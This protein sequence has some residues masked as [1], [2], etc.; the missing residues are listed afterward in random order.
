MKQLF[1]KLLYFFIGLLLIMFLGLLITGC[2]KETTVRQPEK[3]SCYTM[4]VKTNAAISIRYT[5]D[6]KTFTDTN[7][8][9]NFYYSF[10]AP[11]KKSPDHKYQIGFTKATIDPIELKITMDSITVQ[12]YFTNGHQYTISY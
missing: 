11:L 3:I 12:R 9:G 2:K 10:L 8:I 5:T 1:L 6:L 4:Q 7:V